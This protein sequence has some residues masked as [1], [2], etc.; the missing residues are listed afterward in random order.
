M[1]DGDDFSYRRLYLNDN[2]ISDIG[3]A[4]F[5]SITRI[6]TIDLARNEITK[7]DYQM[8]AQLNYIEVYSFSSIENV[9]F[10]L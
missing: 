10:K 6:G 4:T 8:F 3:R 5:G 1:I 9:M 7:I 2:K